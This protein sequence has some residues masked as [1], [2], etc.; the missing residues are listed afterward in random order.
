MLP[1]AL[2][3]LPCS[4]ADIKGQDKPLQIIQN[5]LQNYKKQKKKA[6]LVYGPI[7]CGKTS[8]IHTLA[9]QTNSEIIEINSSDIR[10]EEAINSV[11]GSALKQQSLFFR[12][13][14]ILIDEIDNIS[15]R[16]DRGCAQAIQK[17]L[18]ES[19]YPIILTANNPFDKKLAG[20]RKSSE[21]VE[22]N[23][24][25]FSD[26]ASHLKKICQL[27]GIQFEEKAINSLARIA[28]GD[29][30]SALTDLQLLAYDKRLTLEK[31]NSLSGRKKTEDIFNALKIIFKA[32]SVENT[33]SILDNLDLPLNE[34]FLWLD[35]NLPKEYTHPYDLCQAYQ[36]LSQADVFNQRI[37]KQ[38]YWRFLV[39]INY[40]LTAGLSVSKSRKN[41]QFIQYGPT[42]RILKLWQAKMKNAKKKDLASKLAQQ[43]HSSQKE[44]LK[45]LDYFKTVFKNSDE[46]VQQH[47]SK[48][49]DF[50]QEEEEW[51]QK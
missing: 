45:N 42:K 13:K 26:I 32:T 12:N 38:Q 23:C 14:I 31:I 21:M 22:F 2:K 15:G 33:L 37:H 51:L 39:Y 27:E 18:E 1:F 24:L 8:S 16:E 4:L 47:F 19:R 48:Q 5:F 50:S 20:L 17:L 30:R 9:K 28:D 46:S 36:K 3:Y 43:T 44:A 6:V 40:F 29:L 34:I 41:P 49:F 7:G 25:N 11:I 10:N 35:E